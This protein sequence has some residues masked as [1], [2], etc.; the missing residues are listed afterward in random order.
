[1]KVFLFCC[2]ETVAELTDYTLTTKSHSNRMKQENILKKTIK[3]T[4]LK[5]QPLVEGNKEKL[6]CCCFGLQDETRKTIYQLHF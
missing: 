1:M 4:P 6:F 3:L 5:F 2:A